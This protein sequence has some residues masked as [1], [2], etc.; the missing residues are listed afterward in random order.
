M[1][2]TLLIV[3]DD[4]EIRTQMKWAL[5]EEYEIVMAE[6]RASAVEKFRSVSP[7]VVSLDLGLPPHP[8]DPEE[9]LAT[10][11]ELLGMDRLVKVV[12]ITG[13]GDRNIALQAIGSGAYDFLCKP[14]DMEELKL[15]LKRCFHVATLE[16][17]YR[18]MQQLLGGK[19]FE[20]MMGSSASIRTVF[21][22]IRKVATTDA[23]VLL[24]GESGTGKEMAARAIHQSSGRKDGPFIAINCSAIP[25]TLLE[26]ELFGHEKG[27][28][29]G[30]HALRKGRFESAS[31]GTLFLDEIGEIPLPLQ[32]KLLRFLQE[33]CI[34]R[35]GGRQSIDV[36]ARVVTA[37]NADLRKGMADGTFREDLFYR[38]AVVQITLP[39]L[40][41][42]EDD[43]RLLAQFFLQRFAAQSGKVGLSFDQEALRAL[44]RHPWPG[45]VREMENCIRR[46]VIMAEGKR[47]TVKDLELGQAASP[48]ATLKDA[49]EELERDMIQGALRRHAGRIAPAAQELGV[50]RPTLY[51]LMEKLG[52]G[53]ELKS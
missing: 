37:T 12:V 50:S 27:A 20:G 3:D 6:D 21:E 25:E 22:S 9:G 30:A 48:A 18:D 26:S 35:V 2:P 29:T 45:N 40:R 39:P 51:D 8:G 44:S 5:A 46:A 53:K 16:R 41:D 32:V 23:P 7:L 11:G 15:L 47:L 19:N 13:Q 24:L 42:R 28:F 1:K 43:V 33:K 17:E 38:L 34:E 52:I 10:L 49:R 31:G 14:V 36:D 4:E